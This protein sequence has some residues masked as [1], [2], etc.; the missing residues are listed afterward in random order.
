MRVPTWVFAL[1]FLST[2]VFAIVLEPY[3]NS[4]LLFLGFMGAIFGIGH[5]YFRFVYLRM[6]PVK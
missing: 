4:V 5:A 1:A 3:V 2:F 6:P